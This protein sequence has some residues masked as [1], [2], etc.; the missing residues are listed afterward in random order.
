V[1]EQANVRPRYSDNMV[2]VYE[3]TEDT[4]RRMPAHTETQT[5]YTE[6]S[7]GVILPT[8]AVLEKVRSLYALLGA[9]LF[10]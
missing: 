6:H 8:I 7:S 3:R 10:L 9:G 2:Q 5:C 1:Q 4:G